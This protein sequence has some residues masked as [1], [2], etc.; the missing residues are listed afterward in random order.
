MNNNNSEVYHK[1][2]YRYCTNCGKKNHEYKEC[3]EP[4]ISLGVILIKSESDLINDL[5]KIIDD[6]QID[7]NMNGIR[8]SNVKDIEIFSIFKDSIKFLSIRRKHTFEYIEF[9]RG[10]Y[11]PDNLD[12]IIFLFQQMTQE[13]IKKIGDNSFDEL[14]DDFWGNSEKKKIFEHEY[15]KSK[16]KF[17]KLKNNDAELGLNFYVKNVSPAWDQAEWGFPKGRRNRNETNIECAKREFE[18]ESDL[19]QDDYTILESINPLV[20]EF[21]GTDGV[22]YKHI[23][24]IAIANSLKNPY[25]NNKNPNQNAEIGAIG[26]FSYDEL[27]Q[28]IRPYHIERKKLLTKLYMYLLNKIIT[29]IVPT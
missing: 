26:F 21:I 20:E 2:F 23:Y 12:G 1:K 24:Y 19:K 15:I 10:R 3:R 9:I 13:E 17:E 22:R 4:I 27:I 8:G 28:S 18:E 7:I 5:K 16:A 29:T 6:I 14:W 11:K 25:V